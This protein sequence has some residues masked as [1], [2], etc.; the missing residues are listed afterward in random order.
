MPELVESLGSP[1]DSIRKRAA[2]R[3]QSIVSD[4]S[5]VDNFETAGGIAKLHM[6]ALNANGN[7][8]AYSLAAYSRVL[9]MDQGWSSVDQDLIGRV[10]RAKR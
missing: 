10:G 3:L 4:P 9:E 8:L 6:L 2:F 7:T 1:D 5:F